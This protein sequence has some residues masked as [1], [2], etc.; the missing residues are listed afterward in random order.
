MIEI[1]KKFAYENI[2]DEEMVYEYITGFYYAFTIPIIFA[3]MTIIMSVIYATRRIKCSNITKGIFIGICILLSIT[4]FIIPRGNTLV[5]M[6]LYDVYHIIIPSMLVLTILIIIFRRQQEVLEKDSKA[7]N[8]FM[9]GITFLLI[10]STFYSMKNVTESFGNNAVRIEESRKEAYTLINGIKE[11]ALIVYPLLVN[12]T[13]DINIVLQENTSIAISSKGFVDSLEEVYTYSINT[14]D[15]WLPECTVVVACVTQ[16]CFEDICVLPTCNTGP[17]SRCDCLDNLSCLDTTC[18]A[19]TDNIQPPRLGIYNCLICEAKRTDPNNAIENIFRDIEDSNIL[20]KIDHAVSFV[21]FI[22][23][24]LMA[25][26]YQIVDVLLMITNIQTTFIE[27]DGLW[28]KWAQYIIS[29]SETLYENFVWVPIAIAVIYTISYFTFMY[30]LLV[31]TFLVFMASSVLIPLLF[32]T[33]DFCVV[34]DD[35]PYN[36]SDYYNGNPDIIEIVSGCFVDKG[37]LPEKYTSQLDFASKLPSMGLGISS[38]PI[39][40]DP[41]YDNFYEK[42]ESK[43]KYPPSDILRLTISRMNNFTLTQINNQANTLYKQRMLDIME[44]K[45]LANNYYVKEDIFFDSIDILSERTEKICNYVQEPITKIKEDI[46][47]FSCKP[48]ANIYN[49]AKDIICGDM[50]YHLYSLVISLMF[51]VLVT[52]IHIIIELENVTKKTK[53]KWKTMETKM[54]FALNIKELKIKF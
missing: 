49:T 2:Y 3:C 31:M 4:L 44:I 5:D 7:L 21:R 8:I 54:S 34:L 50:L 15:C 19:D 16:T 22:N 9:Y 37:N 27:E 30:P 36:I 32:L 52:I 18:V 48:V 53:E 20:G 41:I 42:V 47:D 43:R 38:F 13:T 17:Y 26:R 11:T 6:I 40:C 12:I 1:I 45:S 46:V 25:F 23:D 24:N 35:F 14:P 51:M 29:A 28:H 33:S 10:I 39:E